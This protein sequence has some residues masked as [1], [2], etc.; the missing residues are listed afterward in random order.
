MTSDIEFKDICTAKKKECEA[1]LAALEP[2][3]ATCDGDAYN[4]KLR[5]DA[6]RIVIYQLGTLIAEE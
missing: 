5:I 4:L 2:R 6:L 1:R 3:N